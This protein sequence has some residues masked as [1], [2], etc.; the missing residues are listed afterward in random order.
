MQSSP[1]R[2]CNKYQFVEDGALRAVRISGHLSRVAQSPPRLRLRIGC[3]PGFLRERDMDS[4]R[5]DARVVP[6][7]DVIE[8]WP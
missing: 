5:T 4:F 7:V 8:L 6:F 2:W 1:S 3:R